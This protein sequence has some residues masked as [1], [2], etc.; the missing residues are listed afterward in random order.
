LNDRAV[1]FNASFEDQLFTVATT[2]DT[3]RGKH[4]L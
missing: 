1:D 4:L 3:G 2:A